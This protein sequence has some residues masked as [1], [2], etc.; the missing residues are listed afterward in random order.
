MALQS[1]NGAALWVEDSGS[2]TPV[3]FSHSLF[4][5]NTMFHNQ[6]AALTAT[7]RVITY[8]HRG[9]GRSAPAPAANIDTLAEDAAA[10]I[11]ALDAGPC[12]FVGNSLGGFV[13]LRLAARRPELLLS[14]TVLGS[15]AEAEGRIAEFMPLVDA[16]AA[17]GAAPHADTI[18]HIMFGDTF[19]A[20]PAREEE[21]AHWRARIAALPPS[22]AECARAV[23]LRTPVLKELAGCRVPVLAIAGGEDHAYGPAEAAAIAAAAGGR[24]R[25]I[26]QA[27]HSV[28]LEAP[29]DVLG[30]LGQHFSRSKE[31]VLF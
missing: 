26:A 23:V 3:V 2:G 6:V 21:R 14:C 10:L 1:I 5:D 17:Q 18:M 11:E 24:M 31:A 9:Q 16:L 4:F 28:A 25:T 13:A 15:S 29:G 20:D 12:H 7:H 8:D 22:I 30:L 27:G 19:L